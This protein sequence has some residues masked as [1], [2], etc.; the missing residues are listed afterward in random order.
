MECK[1]F[2]RHNEDL[3]AFI[4]SEY[5][6]QEYLPDKFDLTG[7]E[8]PSLKASSYILNRAKMLNVEVIGV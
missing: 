1:P 4:S 8:L 2:A 6:I 7:I 3:I 5:T